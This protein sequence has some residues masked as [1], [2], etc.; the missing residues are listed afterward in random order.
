MG[1]QDFARLRFGIGGD[2]PYGTQVDH[3]LGK[4]KQEESILLQ[5]K[6]KI[7]HEIIQSFGTQ[8][9]D[10]TMNTFNNR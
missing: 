8:G 7:C 9:I 6:I 3:V 10:R 1:H 4:W 2:Y 5:D